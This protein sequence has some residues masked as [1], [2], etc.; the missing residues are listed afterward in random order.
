MVICHIL[1]AERPVLNIVR[2]RS[3]PG[4]GEESFAECKAPLFRSMVN[5]DTVWS[6]CVTDFLMLMDEENVNLFSPEVD[7]D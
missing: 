7:T 4:V 6:F 3:E 1:S 5:S 2:S